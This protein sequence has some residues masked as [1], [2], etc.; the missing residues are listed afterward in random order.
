MNP[1][2]AKTAFTLRIGEASFV[3]SD[4]TSLNRPETLTLGAPQPNPF[5]AQTVILYALPDAGEVR[6][7]IYDLLGRR[8]ATLVDDRREAGP[9]HLSW[10]GE[11][12]NGTAVAS[13]VYFIRLRAGGE[14]RTRKL[15]RVQ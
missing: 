15:V 5:R 11:A 8:V 13:G 10:N 12:D 6:A 3:E 4:G 7:A 2:A 14:R 1:E 9:H